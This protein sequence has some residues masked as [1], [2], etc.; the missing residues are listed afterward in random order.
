MDCNANSGMIRR[1]RRAHRAFTLVELII[2]IV[3]VGVLAAIA[4]VGFSATVNRT[5]AESA[6][7]SALSVSRQMAAL[8]ALDR[9]TD[10]QDHFD[11][12]HSSGDFDSLSIHLVDGS[13]AELDIPGDT[14]RDVDWDVALGAGGRVRVCNSAG[15]SADIAPMG[16]GL[17]GPAAYTNWRVSS[18]VEGCDGGAAILVTAPPSTPTLSVT[19]NDGFV[20]VSVGGFSPSEEVSSIYYSL[21][22]GL[23]WLNSGNVAPFDISPLPNGT[24]VTITVQ[25]ENELGFS[26]PSPAVTVVPAEPFF[27]TVMTSAVTSPITSSSVAGFGAEAMLSGDGKSFVTG[28]RNGSS[29]DFLFVYTL[30][31]STNAWVRRGNDI[32]T[33]DFAHRNLAIST[34]G[35]R[36][37]AADHLTRAISVWDYNEATGLWA[38]SVGPRCSD[39]TFYCAFVSNFGERMATSPDGTKIGMMIDRTLF[40]F[41]RDPST[42]SYVETASKYVGTTELSGF[43]MSADGEMV[44]MSTI[45][46]SLGVATWVRSGSTFNLSGT[47]LPAPSHRPL[48]GYDIDGEQVALSADGS[49]LIVGSYEQNATVYTRV[50]SAWSPL[51][52][53]VATSTSAMQAEGFDGVANGST[54]GYTVDIS[55]DGS[56]IAVGAPKGLAYSMA[57]EGYNFGWTALYDWSGVSWEPVYDALR[58]GDIHYASGYG[59]SVSLSDDGGSVLV[60][61]DGDGFD[62]GGVSMSGSVIVYSRMDQP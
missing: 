50:G 44:V 35:A 16:D 55:A 34:D 12:A 45:D 32:P 33:T 38:V 27:E 30:D 59:E 11:A 6:E 57:G 42:G 2:T 15:W 51:G 49:R 4:V 60:A 19:P 53:P 36:V 14:T 41:E 7:T 39:T 58:T 8:T 48:G 37:I 21:D 26:M 18:G 25:L 3:I 13:G 20:T 1:Q 46:N 62:V 22:G 47:P 40:L 24:P 9:S 61:R 23:T 43:D 28:Y 31:E 54:R 29:T 56:T 10:L 52:A 17:S 5:Q